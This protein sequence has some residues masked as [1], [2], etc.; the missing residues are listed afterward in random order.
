MTLSVIQ[1]RYI[2][3]RVEGIF[4]YHHNQPHAI[5]LVTR[6]LDKLK[7]NLTRGL[8]QGDTDQLEEYGEILDFIEDQKIRC[9]DDWEE[10]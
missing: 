7:K 8:D 2:T 5:K 3:T 1:Q 4:R 10:L 9:V 6:D